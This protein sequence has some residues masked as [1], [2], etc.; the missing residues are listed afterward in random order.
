MNKSGE[1]YEAAGDRL[2]AE[3]RAEEALRAYR[4]AQGDHCQPMDLE[5]YVR[6]QDKIIAILE[7][8]CLRRAMSAIGSIRTAKKAASARENGKRGGRPKKQ[9]PPEA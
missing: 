6:L 4:H 8:D 3:G 2:A 9:R 5:T 7:A 1:Y